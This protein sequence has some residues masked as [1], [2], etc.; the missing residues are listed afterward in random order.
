MANEQDDEVNQSVANRVLAAF[1]A[2]IEEDAD[3]SDIAPRL[4]PV[5]LD[6]DTPKEDALRK[7]IFGEADA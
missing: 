6:T 1:I 3:L 7:A 5:L 4:K 2:A